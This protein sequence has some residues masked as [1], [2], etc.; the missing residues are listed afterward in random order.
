MSV[1]SI[2]RLLTAAT[3]G[4]LLTT[5]VPGPA[6]AAT[7]SPP[8]DVADQGPS[9]G[10][11]T[12]DNNTL[13]SLYGL[14]PEGGYD[15]FV[16]RSSN[17]GATWDTPIQLNRPGAASGLADISGYGNA[18]DVVMAEQ[19]PIPGLRYSRS[20]D[21]GVTYSA[22]V[23]LYSKSQDAVTNPKV[24]RGPNGV[25][26]VIWDSRANKQTFVR[27]SHDGGS[28]FAPRKAL[29]KTPWSSSID[30]VAVGDGVIYVAHGRPD[31][32]QP[33]G[34][35]IRRSLD[36]GATWSAPRRLAKFSTSNGSGKR[37]AI[38]AEGSQAY[39]AYVH[40]T[41]RGFFPAYRRTTDM[42]VTWEP[43][44]TL[45]KSKNSLFWPVIDVRGGVVRAAYSRDLA[46]GVETIYR[47]SIDGVV[48]SAPDIVSPR[49]GYWSYPSGVGY[50]D[51]AVITY[52]F[53]PPV[54]PY[55][56]CSVQV[57]T[58]T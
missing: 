24:A 29:W 34:L 17:N 20:I 53:C 56:D 23:A 51:R 50:T 46:Q 40:S 57:R 45:A 35:Q 33:H 2:R 44:Q 14:Y 12:L 3:L 52:L 13:V 8:V 1:R 10:L 42:G 9:L 19:G 41:A 6:F 21:G 37:L 27:V 16:R 11:V 48:W 26:A 39:V 28:T 58:G 43:R 18:V 55:N 47:E 36:G 22:P 5:L 32:A 4:L 25:V 31:G 7:W 15:F 30:A 38:A 49:P 54:F